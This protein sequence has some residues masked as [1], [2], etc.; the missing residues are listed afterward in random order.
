MSKN[1]I[2]EVRPWEQPSWKPARGKTAVFF[3]L[4]VIHIL[5]IIGLILYPLPSMR[6]LIFA[7]FITALGG[8]GTTI[9]TIGCW[10]TAL[11]R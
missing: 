8:F 3:Y 10:R 1:A 5:A 4:L 9:G 7:L 11:S 6:V 2:H